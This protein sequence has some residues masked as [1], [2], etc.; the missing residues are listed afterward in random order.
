QNAN[1]VSTF[2]VEPVL[3]GRRSVTYYGDVSK[4]KSED[5]LVQLMDEINDFPWEG[6][7]IDDYTDELPSGVKAKKTNIKIDN[8]ATATKY[9]FYPE[10]CV[11]RDTFGD[12]YLCYSNDMP[13]C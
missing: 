9:M 10:E 13:Q 12:Q 4:C 5:S 8:V 6:V 7:D 2:D 11:V 3:S 1:C